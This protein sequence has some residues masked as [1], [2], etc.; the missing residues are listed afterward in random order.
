MKNKG[1]EIRQAVGDALK[2]C[3]QARGADRGEIVTQL[4][5]LIGLPLKDQHG[6]VVKRAITV[7]ALNDLTRTEQAGRS[8]SFPS[9]WVAAFCEVT[10]DDELARLILPE[11]FQRILAVGELVVKSHSTLARALAGLEKL[12]KPP[13]RVA[14]RG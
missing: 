9:E 4:N 6:N 12:A 8:T 7:A 10:G 13:A 3:R 5:E 2:R 14:R 11:R 1:E